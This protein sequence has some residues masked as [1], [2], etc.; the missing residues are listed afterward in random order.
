M[1]AVYADC[2]LT[3]ALANDYTLPY[4]LTRASHTSGSFPLGVPAVYTRLPLI[5]PHSRLDGAELP[6]SFKLRL[7]RLLQRRQG[8]VDDRQSHALYELVQLLNN[9][10][11]ITSLEYVLVLPVSCT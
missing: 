10:K 7:A 8:V 2:T 1:L 9:D 5:S 4:R 6:F 11:S 3:R